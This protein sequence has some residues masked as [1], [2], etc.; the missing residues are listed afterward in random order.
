[1]NSVIIIV[2]IVCGQAD[3]II[4]KMPNAETAKY[5][6]DVRNPAVLDDIVEILKGDHILIRYEEDRGRCA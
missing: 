1:M 5:T 6:H 4:V 3:T 2:L